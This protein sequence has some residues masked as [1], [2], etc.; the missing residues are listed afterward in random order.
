[1]LGITALAQAI[2]SNQ[3]QYSQSQQQNINLKD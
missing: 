3:Y 1:M 2:I